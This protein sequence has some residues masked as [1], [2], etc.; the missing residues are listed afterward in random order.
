MKLELTTEQWRAFG[1]PDVGSKIYL[2]DKITKSK[3]Y[4]NVIVLGFKKNKVVLTIIK[5]SKITK[6]KVK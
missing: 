1:T 5:Q 2:N 6:S 3:Q 4:Y